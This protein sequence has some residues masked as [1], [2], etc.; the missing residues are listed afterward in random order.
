MRERAGIEGTLSQ[1]AFAL[2]MRR[3]RYR[4][5]EK[6]HLQHVLTAS[7]INLLR[8]FAWLEGIPRTKTRKSHFAALMAA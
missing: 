7:A 1:S 4:G 2:D 5:L 8:A 3:S 6:T